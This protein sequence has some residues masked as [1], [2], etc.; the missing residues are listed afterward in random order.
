[1]NT[2]EAKSEIKQ[3]KSQL[4]AA[5]QKSAMRLLTLLFVLAALA[6]AAG[7][8]YGKIQLPQPW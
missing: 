4:R 5:R 8:M 6:V 7:V 2:R 1:M 3:L